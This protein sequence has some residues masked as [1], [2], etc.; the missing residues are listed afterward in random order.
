[1]KKFI[2]ILAVA[3]SIHA[4]YGQGFTG[5]G[6]G[7]SSGL[8]ETV[9]VQRTKELSENSLVILTGNLVQ[10]IGRG[11]YMFRDAT[12]D[13]AVDIDQDLWT[14]LDLSISLSDRVE[15]RGKIDFEKRAVEVDVKYLRKL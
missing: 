6:M 15:I 14:L 13:I 11:K 3:F 8:P 4:V 10:A 9:T 12:G 1:M 2:S 5:P 7:T